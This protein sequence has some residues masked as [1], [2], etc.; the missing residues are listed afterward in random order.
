MKGGHVGD[1]LPAQ[2]TVF[3][4]ALHDSAPILLSEIE[5][6]FDGGLRGVVITH[7]EEIEP[8]GASND[9]L[10]ELF[11]IMVSES[12]VSTKP[13]SPTTPSIPL[14]MASAADLSFKPGSKKV[15]S[16]Q[17]T[18]R[19]AGEVRAAQAVLSVR[20]EA[21]YFDIG[22]KLQELP[23]RTD[24][25]SC[26]EK[27][28]A[29]QRLDLEHHCTVEVLPK[30]PKLQIEL[31]DFKE[32]YY[33]NE[34]VAISLELR[35]EEN[36]IVDIRV[37][38]SLTGLDAPQL[39]WSSGP[40]EELD[41]EGR[42][43]GQLQP[44]K[45]REEI[46]NFQATTDMVEYA[47]EI[48]ASYVLLADP[49]TPISKSVKKTVQIIA[50][51]EASSEFLPRVHP[52][53]WPS[54]FNIETIDDAE[55][56]QGLKQNWSVVTRIGCFATEPLMITSTKLKKLDIKHGIL[57]RLKEVTPIPSAGLTV[58]PSETIERAFDLEVQKLSLTDHQP[59][60]FSFQLEI[61]W[62]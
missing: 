16:L 54:Y 10:S 38:V 31:P 60:K 9:G 50:P 5:L 12:T 36:E 53:P 37:H 33:T 13:S 35:N 39:E 6:T 47:F 19:D 21:F 1:P 32:A 57:N 52:D 61:T 45:T 26:K 29:R 51:F 41:L 25:W 42:A 18:P 44:G 2:L 55:Q 58:Q 43:L 20:E 28:L 17:L 22:V 49:H 8:A 34:S 3:S 15:F 59:C 7:N 56:P 40:A 14:S 27:T 24:W 23:A 11:D 30:P 4:C 48:R 46:V 62:H